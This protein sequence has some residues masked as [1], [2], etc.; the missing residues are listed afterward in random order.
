MKSLKIN[1]K[2]IGEKTWGFLHLL[3]CVASLIS[4]CLS[5]KAINNDLDIILAFHDFMGLC[6]YPFICFKYSICTCSSYRDRR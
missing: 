3:M 6:R 4:L 1:K 2:V 5:N